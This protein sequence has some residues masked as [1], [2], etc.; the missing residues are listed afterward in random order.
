MDKIYSRKR[1]R[2]PKIKPKK[3]NWL[4]IYFCVIIIVLLASIGAFIAASYPIFIASCKS[5]A[6]SKAVN[7]TNEEIENVMNYYTYNDLM[8]IE[9]DANQKVTFMKYNTIMINQLVSQV[10]KNIQKRIDNAPT[11]MV[12]INYGSVSGITIL[13]NFGPKFEIELESAGS[14]NTQL[15]SEFQS[16]GVNQT[17]HKIY[18]EIS[19]N[20]GILTPI[21]S[22]N[23]EVNSKVLLTEAIIVG[24]V[25]QTYY[26]L[27]G[28]R[29]DDILNVLE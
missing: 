8:D 24:E 27:E 14:I 4:K 19:T 2:I 16:V 22:Y 18:L 15:K 12:Y 17:I 6:C 13:K 11:T 9:K 10:T 1:I 20:I 5:A 23:K 21:G 3:I 25:P 28:I 26:N 29:E 7:I